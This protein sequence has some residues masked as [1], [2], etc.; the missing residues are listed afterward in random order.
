VVAE[1]EAVGDVPRIRTDDDLPGDAHVLLGVSAGEHL[2]R[3]EI[4]LLLAFLP[5]GLAAPRLG[6]RD[7]PQIDAALDARVVLEGRL[8]IRH[9]ARLREDAH[10]AVVGDPVFLVRLDHLELEAAA[11]VRVVVVDLRALEHE[12]DLA[13]RQ[14]QAHGELGVALVH[15]VA[16]PYP[17]AH[18][19]ARIEPVVVPALVEV[20]RVLGRVHVVVGRLATDLHHG[21]PPGVRGC[22][23]GP[24]R[25]GVR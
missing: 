22:W 4:R 24:E 19:R 14:V 11:V 8:R 9:V 23:V 25:P 6:D 7:Q 21:F 5:L 15:A 1:A 17:S 20:G 2:G 10:L 16:H 13:V 12:A 3:V 18:P